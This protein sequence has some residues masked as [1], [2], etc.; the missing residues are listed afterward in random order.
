MTLILIR[1]DASLSIGSG[2]VMRCRT[3]AREFQRRGATICFLC[4]RQPG[5]LIALLQRDFPVL[6]LPELPLASHE[7]L[8][9]RSLY[10]AWLGCSQDQDAAD[11]RQAL[12]QA[13][14][15]SADGLVV[16]HYGLDAQWQAQ[17]LDGL[18]QPKLLVIDDLADRPHLADLLLDQNFFGN[19]TADRYRSLVPTACRL[20]LGP[21]YALLGPEYAQL[22][23]LVPPRSE[24]RRVLV[25][26]G[27]VD[28]GNLTGRAIEALQAPEMAE[29]AADVV[30]GLQSPHRQAVC[31]LASRRINTNLYQSFP[32]LAGL[33][34]RADLSIGASG[35]T[36]WERACLGLPT[37]AVAIAENQVLPLQALNAATSMSTLSTCNFEQSILDDFKKIQATPGFVTSVSRKLSALVSGQG[38]SIIAKYMFASDD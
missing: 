36:T 38:C 12:R 8:R 16:D 24:L 25:F 31:E 2:H 26:F 29:L 9:G 30:L 28:P 5:D 19:E 33:I 35:A 18:A 7:G 20:L 11:C 27:G 14:I 37:L 4:R 17:L 32:S 15:R 1:A 10:G 3:V 6:A 21:H 22:H 13:G 23:P 34:A